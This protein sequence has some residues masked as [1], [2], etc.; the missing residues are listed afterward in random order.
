MV[1]LSHIHLAEPMPIE[2]FFIVHKRHRIPLNLVKFFDN[3]RKSGVEV[4][5]QSVQIPSKLPRQH[6]RG[7]EP[8]Q[9]GRHN[10][11]SERNAIAFC[12][13]LV[14]EG[15]IA[16]HEKVKSRHLSQPCCGEVPHDIPYLFLQ[17]ISVNDTLR[18]SNLILTNA[19]L[20]PN[21]TV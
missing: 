20:P 9:R 8:A 17:G 10:T 13:I 12:G 7:I 16:C 11:T 18:P 3:T 4:R 21:E 14:K 2:G 19:A 5:D 6:R 1:R 15:C